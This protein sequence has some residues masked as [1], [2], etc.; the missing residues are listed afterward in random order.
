MMAELHGIRHD[1]AEA[2]SARPGDLL[3]VAI[4]WAG[5]FSWVGKAAASEGAQQG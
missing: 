4:E 5:A 1:L 2:P 3:R